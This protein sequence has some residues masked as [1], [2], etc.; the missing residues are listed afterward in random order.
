MRQIILRTSFV[1]GMGGGALP[2]L[3]RLARFGLGGTVGHGRQGMSWLHEADMNLLFERALADEAMAG[4]YVASS[5]NPV[6]NKIFMREL[7]K[8]VGMPIG[9]PAPAAG[10]YLGAKHMLR[11]DP[12][13]AL[14]GRYV[15][16]KRLMDEGFTFSFDDVGRALRD[17]LAK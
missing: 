13:L 6:S 4:A 5:P 10:V 1:M 17:L 16:P 8:A 11:T 12:E 3:S 9:L 7:R 2:T 15:M 14:L